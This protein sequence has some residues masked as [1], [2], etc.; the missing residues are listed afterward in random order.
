[1]AWEKYVMLLKVQESLLSKPLSPWKWKNKKSNVYIGRANAKLDVLVGIVSN[2][3]NPDNSTTLLYSTLLLY[4]YIAAVISG[5][6]G[7]TYLYMTERIL[8]VCDIRRIA[9]PTLQFQSTISIK[10]INV[11]FSVFS[12][13]RLATY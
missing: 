2:E 9:S 8:W 4:Y 12:S 7:Q 1:V 13:H 6:W 5:W 3:V 10:N 11:S